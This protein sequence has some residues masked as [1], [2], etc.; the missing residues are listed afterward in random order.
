[1]PSPWSE[2]GMVKKLCPFKYAQLYSIYRWSERKVSN[3]ET[4]PVDYGVGFPLENLT[5]G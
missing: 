2:Y 5:N 4:M 1:M 3:S